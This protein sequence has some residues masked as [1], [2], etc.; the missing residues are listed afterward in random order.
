MPRFALTIERLA[1]RFRHSVAVDHLSLEV[2]PGEVF[3]L[4]GPSGCGKTTTL[5]ILAG[6]EVPDSGEV[7]FGERV[8]VSPSARVFVPPHKRDVGMVFQSYAIWPHMTV[9]ENVA[10]P[11]RVRRVPNRDLRVRVS[12]AL[13]KVGLTGLEQR[14]APQ[15][16][17]GQQQRVAFA[18]ALVANPALLLLDEPFSNLDSKLREQMRIQVKD[19]LD[20]Q[21][22]LTVVLVTH[23]QTEALTL[24]DRIAV[25]QSGRIE[26]MGVPRDLYERPASAFVR[27][28]LGRTILLSGEVGPGGANGKVSFAIDGAERFPLAV[29]R[30]TGWGEPSRRRGV[31]AVRPEDIDLQPAPGS[32]ASR[33][34]AESPPAGPDGIPGTVER[35]L[36]VGDH[37][38]CEV[39]LANGRTIRLR[40]DRGSLLERADAV[41][42]CIRNDSA[43]VWVE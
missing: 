27:D 18:R 10:Y 39:R 7:R 5:R 20:A 26:Q 42:V 29:E 16:S 33:R 6:L 28:F 24:S 23:D 13:D 9:F 30:P 3:T 21:Q 12:A 22:D 4:L 14:P 2:R 32:P 41:V 43:R 34:L 17:G 31:V 37:Q 11:L 38:E 8:V 1:K 19:L 35:M 15:L 40:T 25:M 36:F